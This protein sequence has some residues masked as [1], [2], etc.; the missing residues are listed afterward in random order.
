M[1]WRLGLALL[2]VHLLW[3]CG[4]DAENTFSS[5]RTDYVMGTMLSVTVEAVSDSLADAAVDTVFAEVKKLDRLLSHYDPRS[6]LSAVAEYAPEPVH[7]SPETVEFMRRNLELAKA[8]GGAFNPAIGPVVEAW[9]FYGEFPAMPD[10]AVLAERLGLAD[11]KAI[12]LDTAGQLLGI[13]PGMRLDPG[14]TGKGYALARAAKRVEVAGVRS[15]FLDFGGQIYYRGAAPHTFAV[16]HPR[17]D[18]NVVSV[19]RFDSGSVATSGD[20][21][22]YFER[23]GVR[24]SHILDPRSGN[25]VRDRAA[26]SVFASDPFMADALSTILFVLGPDAGAHLLVQYPGTGA[27]FAE[28]RGDSLKMIR[29]GRWDDLEVTP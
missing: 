12:R 5:S 6:E 20:Y 8:S 10:S 15:L 29:V 18:S 27:V 16:R 24:Y 9:G 3:P 19:L 14:A 2:T 7:V 23:D 25:P 11:P 17:S 1:I 28:W 22:R 4:T 21:E 26:V 13:A